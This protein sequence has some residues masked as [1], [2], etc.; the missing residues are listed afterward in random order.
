[1]TT[2][3]PEPTSTSSPGM[4]CE[5]ELGSCR[6]VGMGTSPGLTRLCPHGVQPEGQGAL[7]REHITEVTEYDVEST[8]QKVL[9]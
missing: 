9:H 5:Q 1:M 2:L 3:R 4:G 8:S 7:H 6:V